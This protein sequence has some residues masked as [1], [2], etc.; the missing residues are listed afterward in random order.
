MDDACLTY[1]SP[2]LAGSEDPETAGLGEINKLVGSWPAT[3]MQKTQ[4]NRLAKCLAAA[5]PI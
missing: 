5:K 4:L 2:N 3:H 1:L